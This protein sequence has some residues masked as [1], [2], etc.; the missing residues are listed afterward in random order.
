MNE[1]QVTKRISRCEG[2]RIMN[3]EKDIPIKDTSFMLAKRLKL[4]ASRKEKKCNRRVF[5]A[6]RAINIGVRFSAQNMQHTYVYLY[7]FS[8]PKS[9]KIV[10]VNGQRD[11]FVG[12][13]YD[14]NFVQLSYTRAI[15]I[16]FTFSTAPATVEKRINRS[17]AS[18]GA[19]G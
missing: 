18:S 6:F 11:S 13:V 17:T 5:A 2:I 8:T 16:R 10:P 15:C 3:P 7:K 1:L 12:I 9:N 4:T 14:A 19:Q